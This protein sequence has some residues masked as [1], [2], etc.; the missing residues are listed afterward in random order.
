MVDRPNISIKKVAKNSIFL[1]F[2]MGLIMLFSLISVRILL[3]E[4][5]VEDYG[6]Y[7]AIGGFVTSFA[8]ISSV[9]S[10]AS[11]RYFSYSIGLN[12]N[13]DLNRSFGSILLVYSIIITILLVVGETIGLWFVENKMVYPNSKSV[14]VFWVYQYSLLTFLTTLMYSPFLALIIAK[15]DMKLFAI[16]SIIEGV[17]KLISA[18][19][20]IF[21]LKSRLVLYPL[22]L[23]IISIIILLFYVSVVKNRYKYIRF[24]FIF[25]KGVF[26]SIMS[27][28]SWSL[29]GSTAGVF[30][31]QGISVLFNLFIGPIANAAYAIANQVYS[32]V[33]TFGSSFF[34]AIRP[35]MIKSYAQNDSENLQTLFVLSSKILFILLSLFVFP[36]IAKTDAILNLWL[37]EITPYTISFTR[38]MSVICLVGALGLPITTIVQASGNIR[39]YH[40]L[41]DGFISVSIIGVYYILKSGLGPNSALWYAILVFIIAHF[42]RV[43]YLKIRYAFPI[44]NYFRFF[45]APM[46]LVTSISAITIYLGSIWI[47]INN[48]VDIVLTTIISA[49]IILASSYLFMFNSKDRYKIRS[50]LRKHL[51][52]KLYIF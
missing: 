25:H 30:Y 38:L 40:V 11:Q 33:S 12:D 20:L 39:N 35:G 34:L 7:N 31:H 21:F 8:L 50:I 19:S 2:R 27:F 22:F 24:R 9:L 52:K 10:G 51:L 44:D 5:Q 15:E 49:T 6:I 29:F 41:V 45:G 16:I 3:R 47:N 36:I 37:G 48:I 4:L 42:L 28:T 46:L 13:N 17:L 32:A 1:Y 23:L 26:K 14:Q 43:Y 18:I